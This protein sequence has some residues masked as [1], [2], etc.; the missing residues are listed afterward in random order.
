MKELVT[1]FAAIPAGDIDYLIAKG[2]LVMDNGTPKLT[3]KTYI[4]RSLA[5]SA[6]YS[7]ELRGEIA[8][9]VTD[10]AHPAEKALSASATAGFQPKAATYLDALQ[11]D[12]LFVTDLMPWENITKPGIGAA[13]SLLEADASG[14]YTKIGCRKALTKA[15]ALLDQ[16]Q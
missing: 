16:I 15:I 6:L 3:G 11:F 1:K 5:L 10:P 2:Y 9:E 7:E 14:E 12:S 8:A 13:T 4:A